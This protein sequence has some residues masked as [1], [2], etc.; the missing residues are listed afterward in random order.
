MR[1]NN[2]PLRKRKGSLCYHYMRKEI[3]RY[4]MPAWS[5]RRINHVHYLRETELCNGRIVKIEIAQIH[6]KGSVAGVF[7]NYRKVLAH[8][9][10]SIA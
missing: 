2:C 5:N 1:K 9:Y 8:D 6:I 10:Y 3:R 4:E 7:N